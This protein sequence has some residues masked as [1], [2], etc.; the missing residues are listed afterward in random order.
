EIVSE[1]FEEEKWV[2]AVEC[3]PSDPAVVH[4][5]T[6][7]LVAPGT[8]IKRWKN[9]SDLAQLLTSY[10]DD[11]FLGGYGLGEDPLGL[12]PGEAKRTPKGARIALE[13]PYTPN[14]TAGRDKSRVGL[15]YADGPPKHQVMTGSAMQAIFLVRPGGDTQRFVAVKKFDRAA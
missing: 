3:R 14:G 15:I 7:F 8:D 4:H 6:A 10:S 12:R 2:Q 1:P 11:S 13:L 9:Q 5:I